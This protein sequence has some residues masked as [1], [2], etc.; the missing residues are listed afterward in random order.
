MKSKFLFKMNRLLIGFLF[1]QLIP[2]ID[3]FY[4]CPRPS[5][6]TCLS[7]LIHDAP[8]IGFDLTPSYG[9]ANDVVFLTFSLL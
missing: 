3:A 7:T 9:W 1:F 5:C 4:D 8:G 2:I 6:E